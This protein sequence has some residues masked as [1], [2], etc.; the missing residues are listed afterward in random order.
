M[1][2]LKRSTVADHLIESQ[3]VTFR[4]ASCWLKSWWLIGIEFE[5]EMLHPTP[6]N[7]VLG[8]VIHGHIL[9]E[10]P[11]MYDKAFFHWKY[12]MGYRTVSDD[13]HSL[14]AVYPVVLS[15]VR[16]FNLAHFVYPRGADNQPNGCLCCINQ[17]N[18]WGG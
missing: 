14:T 5:N 11:L 7:G 12:N 16:A 3:T 2:C 17:G 10:F 13:G 1:A 6:V 9:A 8:V 15:W 18:C 4:T